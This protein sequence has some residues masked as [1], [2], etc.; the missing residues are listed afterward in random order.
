MC[1]G[2]KIIAYPDSIMNTGII[3]SQYNT[4]N[5]D[6][7]VP[8]INVAG[9]P[10]DYILRFG[11]PYPN[12]VS[13]LYRKL[14]AKLNGSTIYD[15]IKELNDTSNYYYCKYPFLNNKVI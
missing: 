8:L 4:Y 2:N 14:D 5:L 10:F 9:Y 12:I 3:L 6:I 7:T 1:Q 15:H 13:M 11:K